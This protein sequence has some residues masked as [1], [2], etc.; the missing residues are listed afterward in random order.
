[1]PPVTADLAQAFCEAMVGVLHGNAAIQSAM[2]RASDFVIP[3]E[4]SDDSTQLPCYVY[5]YLRDSELGGVADERLATVELVAVAEGN[6][7]LK[8]TNALCALARTALTYNALKAQGLEAYV[9]TIEQEGGSGEKEETRGL[10]MTRL[11]LT[12]RATAP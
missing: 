4:D 2:G 1:M 8:K 10:A 5:S 6:D 9:D 12:I 3:F 11:L 7:A